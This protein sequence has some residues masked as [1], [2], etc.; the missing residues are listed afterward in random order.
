[1]IDIAGDKII[2][3]KDGKYGIYSNMFERLNEEDYEDAHLNDN[4]M[5][6]VKERWKMG[7]FRRKH[8]KRNRF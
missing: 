3:V 6:V 2:G 5:V 7:S 8:E 4:G 1:M